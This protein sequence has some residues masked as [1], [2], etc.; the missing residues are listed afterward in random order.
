MDAH[1]GKPL[2]VLVKTESVNI[3]ANP[4]A[5][6]G[7]GKAIAG[8]LSARLSADGY[9]VRTWFDPPAELTADAAS[10]DVR[11]A[12]IVGGDGTLRAVTQRL[13]A[14]GSDLPPL[15]PVPLGT[16]NLMARHLGYKWDDDSLE[17]GVSDAIASLRIKTLDMA[18]AN[19]QLFLLIAGIGF[20]AS[21]V[22]ELDKMRKGPIKLSQ[23]S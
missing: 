16:A 15:L 9:A 5:G 4:I 6:R 18:T 23:L 22:H 12:I 11:A 7:L 10:G 20:D 2:V 21:V 14:L 17:P 3:F 8:R 1:K 13:L 19:G